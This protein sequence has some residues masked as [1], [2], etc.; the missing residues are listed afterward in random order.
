MLVLCVRGLEFARI[1]WDAVSASAGSSLGWDG[2]LPWV[3][4]GWVKSEK[5][6]V[7]RLW[8][9][10]VCVML[11]TFVEITRSPRLTIQPFQC[12]HES[13]QTWLGTTPAATSVIGLESV[14]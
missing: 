8:G 13:I 11:R 4:V 9:Y 1:E 2:A 14:G 10:Y 12:S 3:L 6:V 5:R 7:V